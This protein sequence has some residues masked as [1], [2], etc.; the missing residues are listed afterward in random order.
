[1]PARAWRL[2]PVASLHPAASGELQA[3][4]ELLQL[5]ADLLI[6]KP[7]HL[8]LATLLQ[9][10]GLAD[11]VHARQFLDRNDRTLHDPHLLP[12]ATGLIAR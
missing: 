12:D 7:L 3:S 10:R 6:P 2:E 1:M 4:A 9:S 8:S 5:F 11:P